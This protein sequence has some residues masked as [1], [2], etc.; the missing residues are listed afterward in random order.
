MKLHNLYS[1][2]YTKFTFPCQKTEI[3]KRKNLTIKTFLLK[4]TVSTTIIEHLNKIFLFLYIFYY[5]LLLFQPFLLNSK[6]E[7]S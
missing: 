6:S 5:A 3:H 4:R 2:F 7:H 1:H